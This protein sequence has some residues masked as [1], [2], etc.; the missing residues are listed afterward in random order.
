MNKITNELNLGKILCSDGA[1]GTYL[2]KKGL[3]SG[4]CP[5]YWNLIREE[6]VYDVAK[7]YVDSGAD[8]IETNS[9]GANKFKLSEFGLIDKIFEINLKAAEISRRVAGK[10]KFVMGSIGP[11]GKFLIMGDVTEAELYESYKE[12]S[13]A[14]KKG[15][16]D[17]ICLETFYALDEAEL[18]IKA[19]KENTDLE[20]ICTFSF[21]KMQ[22]GSFK[23]MMGISPQKMTESLIELGVDIVGANC[24]VGFSA[25]INII[26]GIREISK[27][28]PILIQ[29]NAGLP[30]FK[31]GK[32]IYS[33][34]PEIIKDIVPK[35]IDEGANI[36][37]GCCG[38]MPEH[39]KTIS[40]IISEYNS[41]KIS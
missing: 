35:F 14:L 33:E 10:S 26:K 25:M 21:D 30:E 20:I 9:F 40:K 15:G 41:N 7:S 11:S 36:V 39:I 16:A 1:W 34:T 32:L 31:D 28:V 38:T 18:A 3:K 23:S 5:E 29:A 8:I 22:D 24:G 27:E 4:S 6:D 17:A 13:T 19:V 2:F 37:G 12:Q